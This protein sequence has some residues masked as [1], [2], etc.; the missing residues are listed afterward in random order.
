MKKTILSTI[1]LF[2]TTSIFAQTT[3]CF[4]ENH[5]SMSTI[6]TTALNGG[7][8]DG[9]YSVNDMKKK[10]G[11]LMISKSLNQQMV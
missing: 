5:S 4:K 3:M 11:L 8:C 6:E 9:K 1:L 7:A 2:G 10:V